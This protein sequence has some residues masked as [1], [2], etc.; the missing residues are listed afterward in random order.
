MTSI[1]QNNVME[2][3]VGVVRTKAK[4]FAQKDKKTMYSIMGFMLYLK[5]QGVLEEEKVMECLESLPL[6]KTAAE[7]T[8]F[9][10][11]DIFDTKKVED[12][13]FKPM[14]LAHKKSKKEK[15]TKKEKQVNGEEVVKKPRAKKVKAEGEEVQKRGRKPKQQI[16]ELAQEAVDNVPEEDQLDVLIQNMEKLNMKEEVALE[17]IQVSDIDNMVKEL[18]LEDIVEKQDPVKQKTKV[19]KE[20]KKKSEEPKKKSEEPK[21]NSEEPKKK[22]STSKSKSKVV[23]SESENK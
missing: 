4:G 16:V 13:I 12:E 18:E 8:S 23:I 1:E 3:E 2:V 9:F 6:Y 22:S 17:D 10:Q 15:K 14:V 11:Q 21:N 19:T 7:K 5:E 20:S